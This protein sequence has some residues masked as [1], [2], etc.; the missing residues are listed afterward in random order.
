MTY[1]CEIL[2]QSEQPVLSIR[3]RS[4]VQNLPQVLGASWGAI[5]QYMGQ[6]GEQPVGPPFVAYYNMDMQ[7]L[8]SEV[9]FPVGSVLA[10]KGEVGA[11]RIDAGPGATCLHTGPYSDLEPAYTALT[12]W[13]Q[14]HGHEAAGVSYEYY[15]NDPDETPPEQLQTRVVFPLKKG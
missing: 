3:T 1:Q 8:D 7:D 10:G 12:K 14:E 13:M 15:L 6:M 2:D 9:G 5:M 4:A 11:S